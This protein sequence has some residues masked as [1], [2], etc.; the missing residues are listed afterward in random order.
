M[1]YHIF[2]FSAYCNDLSLHRVLQFLMQSWG[3]SVFPMYPRAS[4]QSR[5]RWTN[6]HTKKVE[7]KVWEPTL[8]D[9]LSSPSTILFEPSKALTIMSMGFMTTSLASSRPR[10]Q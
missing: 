6:V 5:I 4:E 9:K 3:N 7:S 8:I 10:A 2:F 1:A